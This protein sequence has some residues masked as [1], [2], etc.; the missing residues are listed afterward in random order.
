MYPAV[1]YMLKVNNRNT[2]SICV[3]CSKV[4]I[5]LPDFTHCSRVFIVDFEQANAGWDKTK[6]Q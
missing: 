6:T 2:R 5:K 4:T 3:I 1:I